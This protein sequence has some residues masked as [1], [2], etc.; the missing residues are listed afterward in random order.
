MASTILPYKNLGEALGVNLDLAQVPHKKTGE[1]SFL[2]DRSQAGDNI[3]IDVEVQIPSGMKTVFPPSEHNK[4]PLDVLVT[5]VSI[6]GSIRQPIILKQ[7]KASLY[8]G[9]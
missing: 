2:V 1:H 8:T 6:D 7:Q 4:L 5:V 3:N 9:K